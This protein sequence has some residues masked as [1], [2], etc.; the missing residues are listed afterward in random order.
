MTGSPLGAEFLARPAEV[1]ARYREGCPVARVSTP[2]GRPVWLVTRE[3]EVRAAFTDP[4][5]SLRGT[6]PAPGRP[7][8]ALD[9]TLVNYDPPDHTRIRRL[10]APAF[11]PGRIS[12]HRPLAERL[13]DELLGGLAG[14]AR[15][16]ELM[17]EYAE[18]FAFAMLREVFGF[19]PEAGGVIRRAVADL[20]AHRAAEAALD[21]LDAVVRA[22]L[23]D[24]RAH[25]G[26]GDVVAQVLRA[27]ESSGEVTEAEL[28]DL[29]AMLVLAGFDS[30][31]QMIGMAVLALLTHPEEYARLT[32]DP[33]LAPGAVDELLRWDTPGP[34]GT[35]RTALADVAIGGTVIPAGSGVLLAVTAAN[36]DPRSHPEP[37]R[38]D[39]ARPGA[40]R[41]LSFGAGPHYCLGAALAK[42][43]LTA[44]LEAFTRHW[45][46]ARLT[47][48]P[49]QY[50]GG[51]Q[52][53]RLD[54]LHV[55][56]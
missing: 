53:R 54:A 42:L 2:A 23:A 41:H 28:V 6:P 55:L 16:V 9:M 37:D 30:T 46:Q 18:P 52:H 32:A 3:A 39:L 7:H 26:G 49:P 15:P 29:I 21:G 8:R 12:A 45:P 34:F 51:H 38:L 14:Q 24:R 44:T 56:N 43:E 50:S 22:Q 35:R 36:R 4:R 1:L 33:G 48:G 17:T 47:G 19:P 11:A 31:V 10:A 20:L 40:A 13:A 27:W 5:L 25:P